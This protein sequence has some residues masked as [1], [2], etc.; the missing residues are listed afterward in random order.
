MVL[1]SE[2]KVVNYSE[3]K[4]N[5]KAWTCF[6]ADSSLSTE[7]LMYGSH[8]VCPV[9]KSEPQSICKFNLGRTP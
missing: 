7:R 3:E 4:H 1:G 8:C 2:A 5:V 9:E 6:T